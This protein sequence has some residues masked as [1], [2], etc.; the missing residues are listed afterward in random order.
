[1][2]Y[3]VLEARYIRDYVIWLRFRDG[4]AGEV[5][6]TTALKGQVFEPVRDPSFFKQFTINEDFQTLSWPNGADLAP[7]YLY[8]RTRAAGA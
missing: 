8:D 5:D 3:D 7:E 1:M 2:N 4:T 6:L